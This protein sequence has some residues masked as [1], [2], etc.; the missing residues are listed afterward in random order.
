MVNLISGID[1]LLLLI[2]SI[3]VFYCLKRFFFRSLNPA[4]TRLL[5]VFFSLKILAV[6]TYILLV[7]YYWQLADSVSVYS[8]TKNFVSL[9]S[10]D[11]SNIK[12]L[13]LPVEN[14]N[15]AINLDVS[16]KAV[17]GGS[18]MEGNFSLTRL[19]T[20]L[21]PLSLGKYLLLNFWFGVISAI[22]QFKLFLV[23]TKVYPQLKGKL[24]ICILFIPT[25]L[26][27]GSPIYKETLCMSC[28]CL[29]G[30][31]VYNV[32]KNRKPLI[33]SLLVILFCFFIYLV[34]PYVL[35]AVLI[36]TCIVLL[37]RFFARVFKHSL[38]G[39]AFSLILLGITIAL[40]V[41]NIS[42][43]DSYVYDFIDT[44]NINQQF[45]GYT[46]GENSSFEFGEIETSFSG[47]I[48]KI[49]LSIYTCYFRPNLWEINQPILLFCAL[50]SLTCFLLLCYTIVKKRRNFF[51]VLRSNILTH[52]IFIYVFLMGIIVGTTTFNFGS[53]MRYKVPAVPFLWL[54]IF[55][56]LYSDSD[57]ASTPVAENTDQTVS[58]DLN[59]QG[60]YQ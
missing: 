27:Y 5:V 3:V 6:L 18:G 37:S 35:S 8:E 7:V 44:A 4:F 25:V 1:F 13:F 2:Y 22:A 20:I 42:Y 17:P 30:V 50:E 40:I 31:C 53:L 59:N 29:A 46:I 9:I 60:T 58:P 49:P 23:L 11:I 15:A 19:C 21:Y 33:N 10:A 47:L 43:F 24:A 39:K 36:A 38:L 45:Y 55:I 48:K 14:Y 57:T 12:Y 26:F 52:I 51:M 16:L 41:K 54:F 34:K 32:I 28:L 56:L